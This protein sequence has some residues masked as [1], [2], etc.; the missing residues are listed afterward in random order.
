MVLYNLYAMM[1]IVSVSY[2]TLKLVNSMARELNHPEV[3]SLW[4]KVKFRRTLLM[5][6][7]IFIVVLYV[8]A[9]F[10]SL[11]NLF[12]LFSSEDPEKIEVHS[13]DFS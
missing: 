10:E 6:C 7:Q 5:T 2:H 12:N 8:F 9:F 4:N 3:T 11:A 13:Y 1:I